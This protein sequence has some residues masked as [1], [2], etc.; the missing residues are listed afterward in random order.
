[1]VSERE[2]ESLANGLRSIQK[3]FGQKNIPLIQNYNLP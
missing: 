1:M 3:R 2:T